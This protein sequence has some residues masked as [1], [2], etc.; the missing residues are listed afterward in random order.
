MISKK[1][2]EEAIKDK[3]DFVKI[4][5]LKRYLEKDIPFSLKKFVYLK[6]AEIYEGKELFGEVARMY[7]LIALTS[8]TF[9]EKI[10]YYLKS[11]KFY[12]R[13]LNFEGAEESIKRV[14]ENANVQQRD[15]IIKQIKSFYIEQARDFERK[16]IKR[17]AVAVYERIIKM[18]TLEESER[19]EVRDK[20]RRLY[21]SLGLFRESERV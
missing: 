5:Y 4:D 11:I 10:E 18:K 15:E 7:Y 8:I 13:D 3:G 16:G 20:L 19:L 1:E 2:I 12:V 6:L 17:K 9:R 14:V 21:E